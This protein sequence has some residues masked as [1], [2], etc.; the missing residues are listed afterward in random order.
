MKTVQEKIAIMQAF[1][2]GKKIQFY[3]HIKEKWVTWDHHNDPSFDWGTCDYRIA[4]DYE[5]KA[6]N[7]YPGF[8]RSATML[9]DNSR[10]WMRAIINAVKAGEIQ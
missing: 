10:K 5:L 2:D 6:Y 7:L 3:S 8:T 1:V 4:E 9:Q